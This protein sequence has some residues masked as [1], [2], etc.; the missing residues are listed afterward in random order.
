MDLRATRSITGRC[1]GRRNGEESGGYGSRRYDE[2]KKLNE[3]SPRSSAKRKSRRGEGEKRKV[4]FLLF[5]FSSRY[6]ASRD[7]FLE[8]EEEGEDRRK[9]A[10]SSRGLKGKLGKR[11]I[12]IRSNPVKGGGNVDHAIL[13]SRRKGKMVLRD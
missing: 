2:L 1:P 8:M 9:K 11:R 10:S 4:P 5:P 6:D 13:L 12:E 3:I 7:R